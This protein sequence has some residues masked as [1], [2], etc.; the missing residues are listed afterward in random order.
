MASGEVLRP[1]PREL[2]A[3]GLAALAEAGVLALPVWLVLT[4]TRGLEV[5]VMALA[6]P[7]VAVYVGGV[8]LACRFRASPN[9]AIVAAVLAVLAG[10]WLG[11][12]DLNR[13][14]FAIVVCSPRLVPA[15]H[16][17]PAGLARPDP[18]GGRVVRPGTRPRGADRGRSDEGV[19]SAAPAVRPGVLRG[20]A[21]EQGEH[22][23]DLGRRRRAGRT[24]SSR[25]DPPGPP[26]H[27]RARGRDGRGGRAEHRGRRLRP[28]RGVADPRGQRRR[29]VPR[30]GA[31]AGRAADLLAGRSAR[32]RP[33][34]RPGVPR[35]PA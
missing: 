12:G 2:R 32:H 25:V 34:P 21:R 17:R 7:F 4:E 27:R 18:R 23:V 15:R 6:V 29:H 22:R 30:V 14:V 28:D 33:R 3:C 10:I 8:L 13:T 9:V 20:G 19:A 11:H 31:L 16:A 24:G 35:E 1:E 5:G 26:R